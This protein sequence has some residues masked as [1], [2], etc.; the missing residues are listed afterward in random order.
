MGEG[1]AFVL[2]GKAEKMMEVVWN[3][4]VGDEKSLVVDRRKR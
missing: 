1:W 4:K 2:V 3:G